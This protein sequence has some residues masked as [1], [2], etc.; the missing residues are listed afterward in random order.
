MTSWNCDRSPDTT[1]TRAPMASLFPSARRASTLIQWFPV[2]PALR[3]R[4]GGPEMVALG[5]RV[6]VGTH[7]KYSVDVGHRP[8][9]VVAPPTAASFAE[10]ELVSLNLPPARIWLTRD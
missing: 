2:P 10:G 4:W 3:S 9:Q 7:V 6:Y 8:W 5:S 1:V